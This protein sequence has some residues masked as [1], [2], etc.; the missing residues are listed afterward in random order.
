MAVEAR[1]RK[2]VDFRAIGD[3]WHGDYVQ[4]R[5]AICDFN[6]GPGRALPVTIQRLAVPPQDTDCAWLTLQGLR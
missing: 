2:D 3:F 4:T 1:C 6:H 5:P